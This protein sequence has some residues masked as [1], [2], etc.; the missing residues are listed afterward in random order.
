MY[1]RKRGWSGPEEWN[2][3]IKTGGQE[4]V[5]LVR[6]IADFCLFKD[7]KFMIH[8]ELIGCMKLCMQQSGAVGRVA[9]S[10]KEP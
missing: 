5:L 6:N 1:G 9:L 4:V 7:S 2:F 8:I 3:V 10:M